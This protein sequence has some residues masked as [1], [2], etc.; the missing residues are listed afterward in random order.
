MS[1][2]A[3][4]L[5]VV[6]ASTLTVY[7][8]LCVSM[9]F[10]SRRQLGQLT[11]LDLLIII[12]LG[13][14]VETAMVHGDSSLKAGIISAATLFAA[15]TIIS[16][17]I[18]R[19]KA[20][21]HACGIGPVLLIHDGRYVEEHLKRVGLTHEDVMHALRQREYCDLSNIRFAVLEAD[22]QI[23]VIPRDMKHLTSSQ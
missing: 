23:N 12:L 2:T 7:V 16:R 14:A 4:S 21:R 10:L 9:R 3:Q 19:S 15:N 11:A 6:S 13:S 8:F 22:G 18:R 20:F 17:L 5:M 1:A